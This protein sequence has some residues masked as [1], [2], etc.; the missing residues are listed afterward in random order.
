MLFG[1]LAQVFNVNI[2]NPMLS[3]CGAFFLCRGVI[4]ILYNDQIA[5]IKQFISDKGFT[6]YSNTDEEIINPW[7]PIYFTAGMLVIFLLA[8]A[9]KMQW[10]KRQFKIEEHP[11]Y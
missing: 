11:Y 9:W 6:T 7:R 5:E 10:L 8:E 4:I 3:F 2:Y 1:V